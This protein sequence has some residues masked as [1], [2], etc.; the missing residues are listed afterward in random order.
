MY[1]RDFISIKP[2]SRYSLR[3][4]NELLLEYPK[5]RIRRTLGDRAFCAAAPKLWN[6]LPNNISNSRTLDIFK[7]LLKTHLSKEAQF[8]IFKFIVLIT[9]SLL[10][11]QV[12]LNFR[13][14]SELAYLVY[15]LY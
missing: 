7:V 14:L 10:T 2:L 6:I 3:S 1:I 8:I 9:V 13:I 5:E 11:L 4:I 12:L 15:K